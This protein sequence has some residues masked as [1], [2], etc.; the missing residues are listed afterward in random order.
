ME[1]LTI[2]PENNEQLEAVKAVLKAL[3][4]PF[5]KRESPYD[6]GFINKVLEAE[7]DRQNAMVLNNGDD[8]NNYFNNLAD[9]VQD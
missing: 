9:D 6:Q 5:V 4:I 1:V 8:I 7:K 3:K 2:H